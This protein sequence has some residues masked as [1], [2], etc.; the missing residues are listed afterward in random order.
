MKT[1]RKMKTALL[2]I[3]FFCNYVLLSQTFTQKAN[4]PNGVRDGG[5]AFTIGSKVYF[6][7]GVGKKDLWEYDSGLNTWVQK[8][9][10]PGVNNER[11]FGVG[12]TVGTK[13]YVGLG[14]DGFTN[15]KKDWW[16]Y[17]STTNTW[18]QKANFPGIARDAC[19][20]FEA[21]G[22]IYVGGGTD[23]NIVYSDFYE[24]DPGTNIWTAKGNLPGGPRTFPAC[25]TINNKGYMACG[26][27]TSETTHLYEYNPLNNT[28]VNKASF[29]GVARQ[30]AIGFVLNNEGYVGF[31]MS[32]YSI[33]YNNMF[34]YNPS[35]NTWSS[36]T[37]NNTPSARCWLAAA[38]LN[39]KA[40]LGTGL[41]NF[42]PFTFT[43]D[44]YEFSIPVGTNAVSNFNT[45]SNTCINSV[46][47]M[48]NN[49]TGSPAPTYTWSTIPVALISN[50][51]ATNPNIS[52]SSGGI[53]TI[54][55]V[56]S[57][58]SL[59][60]VSST[61][62]NVMPSPTVNITLSSSTLCPG[63]TATAVASGATSYTW[64]PGNL[65]GAS[66]A[67][68]PT[69]TQVYTITG[70]NG[71]CASS[72]NKTLTVVVCTGIEEGI[73]NVLFVNAFPNPF[74]DELTIEVNEP[75]QITIT[76]ALGQVVKTLNVNGKT[77]LDTNDLPK[78]LYVLTI[79]TQSG[80]RAIKL[81]KE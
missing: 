32:G 2:S 19:A 71:S 22:K 46:I 25:F 69:S 74:K 62:I 78:A 23:N 27:T 43:N 30:A 76:N 10:V 54:S 8:A 6:A 42:N 14:Y 70:S 17:N 58:S 28:W 59:T 33:N 79:K 57:N 41:I 24:Y 60:S 18:T 37:T 68:S 45:P 11:A 12:L 47:T 52:F 56:A 20:Y 13:A 72:T 75:S 80:S 31:G 7:A 29:P 16:E 1:T 81:I 65:S 35:N 53:Y 3:L 51:S 55:L 48:T 50:T 9:N 40:Y 5:V 26:A 77:T 36:V 64:V 67:L 73:K 61:T 15:L 38:T 34:K 49:S 39:N 66:Q 44:F 63:Q 21:N 4:L